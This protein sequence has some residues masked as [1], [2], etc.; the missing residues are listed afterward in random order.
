MSK[1][2]SPN[3]EALQAPVFPNEEIAR[4]LRSAVR[5]FHEAI[6]VLDSSRQ[7]ETA[8]RLHALSV[9]L[10]QLASDTETAEIND[11]LFEVKQAQYLQ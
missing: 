8:G 1:F 9:E 5:D 11:A 10:R 4:L 3:I 6:R 7:S 2:N